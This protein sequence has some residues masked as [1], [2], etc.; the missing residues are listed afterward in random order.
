[1][2]KQK[3]IVEVPVTSEEE[4]EELRTIRMTFC[5][6][7]MMVAKGGQD[8][9]VNFLQDK[10]VDDIKYYAEAWDRCATDPVGAI[11]V[12]PAFE[13]MANIKQMVKTD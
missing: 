4:R 1:M 8:E 9:V 11:F 12:R 3:K 7:V 5:C 6:L 13:L 2:S 10:S